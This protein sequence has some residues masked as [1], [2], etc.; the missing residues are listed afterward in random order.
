M[1]L[2]EGQSLDNGKY[3]I[4]KVISS[5]DFGTV[6]QANHVL[7]KH[8]VAIKT[9]LETNRDHFNQEVQILARISNTLHYNIVKIRDFFIEDNQPYLVMDFILGEN[10][11]ES[12]KRECIDTIDKKLNE[13]SDV[14]IKDKLLKVK[15][16]LLNT[17]FEYENFNSQ[18]G[19]IY[20]LK[21]SID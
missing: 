2:S 11:F 17:N 15:D 6:Y 16:K 13:S 20:N 7:L 10:L 9:P 4:E 8:T 5:G 18:I 1:I 21:E 12:V 14:E 19:K 3:I